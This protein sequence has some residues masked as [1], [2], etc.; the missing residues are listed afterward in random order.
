LLRYKFDP[1][2]SSTELSEIRHLIEETRI[3]PSTVFRRGSPFHPA[4]V[5]ILF[6]SLQIPLRATFEEA[7][8]AYNE[9]RFIAAVESYQSILDPASPQP[10]VLYNLGTAY[11]QMDVRGRAIAHFSAALRE[12]PRATDIRHNLSL[13]R[14]KV[15]GGRKQI[16][17]AFLGRFIRSLSLSEW[18][19]LLSLTASVTMLLLAWRVLRPG[20]IPS[21]FI[22]PV[23]AFLALAAIFN[24]CALSAASTD[25]SAMLVI[26]K[27]VTFRFG[28]TKNSET[29]FVLNDG[30]EIQAIRHHGDWTFARDS[31]GRT[32]WVL[33]KGLLSPSQLFGK[34]P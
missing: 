27:E 11:L 3:P 28:P 4:L 6:L 14:Q 5:I 30:T 8:K 2:R 1:D 24:L 19:K 13:A 22:P 34:S 26:E 10:V 15:S 23:L 25:D 7:N 29:L 20:R 16:Q 18:R 21:F 9:G 17:Q 31:A 32:G 33:T 12:Q